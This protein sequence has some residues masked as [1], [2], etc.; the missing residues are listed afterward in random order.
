[1]EEICSYLDIVKEGEMASF[2]SGGFVVEDCAGFDAALK[3]YSVVCYDYKVDGLKAW[4]RD[5]C[6]KVSDHVSNRIDDGN[7]AFALGIVKSILRLSS[8]TEEFVKEAGSAQDFL[9]YYGN[10]KRLANESLSEERQR[11]DLADQIAE[12]ELSVVVLEDDADSADSDFHTGQWTDQIE[13]R[14]ENDNAGEGSEAILGEFAEGNTF[15]FTGLED[16]EFVSAAAELYDPSEED[17]VSA[18]AAD[19]TPDS[20]DTSGTPIE[21]SDGKKSEPGNAA[22]GGSSAQTESQPEPVSDQGQELENVMEEELQEG[23]Q[24]PADYTGG[25]QTVIPYT[26]LLNFAN[27][28]RNAANELE[29]AEVP[30]TELLTAKDKQETLKYLD[31]YAPSVFKEFT[32]NYVQSAETELDY[33]RITKMLDGF[34]QFVERRTINLR[35]VSYESDR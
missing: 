32:L 35:E 9:D 25:R 29:S 27:F 13:F 26:K 3:G 6:R 4:V 24:I 18:T 17:S 16:G 7:G 11:D 34:C 28:I 5:N 10:K 33:V 15:S 1:M 14:E 8:F 20:P 21:E 31:D 19:D 22:E 30:D 23:I 2:E 12:G